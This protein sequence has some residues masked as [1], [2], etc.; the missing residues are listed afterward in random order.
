MS[1]AGASKE[2]ERIDYVASELPSH[3]A[4]LVRLLVKQVRST[5]I[6]RAEG[7]VL[8]ILTGGPRRVT[9]L[10]ELAGFAQPTMTALVKRLERDGWVARESLP[11]D[12]RVVIVTIT[13]AGAGALEGFRERFRA[14]MRSDLEGLSREELA[15]LSAATE[16]VGLLV[17]LLQRASAR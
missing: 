4:L 2:A 7:E 12:G 17:D 9:E 3:A 13:G 15:A 11:D 8:G 1:A 14:A 5:D 10:A 16:T 6:S